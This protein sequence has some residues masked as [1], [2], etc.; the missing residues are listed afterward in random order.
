MFVQ[1][2]IPQKQ[3]ASQKEAELE[4]WQAQQDIQ[5]QGF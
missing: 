4:D 1:T 5:V 3:V 2:L